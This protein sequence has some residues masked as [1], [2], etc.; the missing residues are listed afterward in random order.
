MDFSVFISVRGSS[1]PRLVFDIGEPDGIANDL[2]DL[3]EKLKAPFVSGNAIIFA[4][5]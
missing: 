3:G 2:P 4:C 5:D 1:C